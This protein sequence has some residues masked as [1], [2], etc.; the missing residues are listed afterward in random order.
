MKWIA[1][2][3]FGL[4]GMTGRDLKRL[5]AENVRVMDVGG[6]MFE[7]GFEMGFRANLWLRT[8]DRVLL[9]MDQ[10]EARSF[11]E[12]FQGI[13]RIAWEELLPRDARF[14]IRAKCVKSQLMS[15]SDVQKISKRAMVERLKGAYGLDWFSETGALFQVDVSIRND[16]VTVT[17]DA[18]G[19]P[20]SKRG[21]RTWNGEAP[22]RETLAAALVLQSGWHPWQKLY[23]PCCGTGTIL[24]EAAFV[25]L[26]RAPG[27]TRHFAMEDWPCVPGEALAQ[28]RLEARRKY[29]TCYGR[30]LHIA[31]S[32]IDP[33]AIELARRHVR[34]AG[35]AGRIDLEVKDMRDVSLAGEPGVFIANPPYGERLDNARAAHAVARQLGQLQ[36]RCPGWNLCAFSADMGFE[37]EYGRRAT[38]RR[39]YYNGRIECEYH[40]FEAGRGGQK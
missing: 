7:G 13:R 18:S 29:D 20:L 19:D 33:E 37:R 6:A 11:E 10:F 38:R 30:D 17:L 4:E 36:R 8:A 34:Q 21:Y 15:P 2:A 40:I 1:S 5:G 23:D 14:P 22:L 31:G 9:V 26:N 16:L 35:L 24:V 12:L 25:A 39:R 32:D 27:L 3:A 28:I